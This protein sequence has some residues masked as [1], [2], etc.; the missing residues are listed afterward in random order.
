MRL[1]WNAKGDTVSTVVLW[2]GSLIAALVCVAWLAK[3]LY[4]DHITVQAVD[5]ELTVL[6]HDLNTA[7]RMERFWKNYYPKVKSGTLLIN[8][9]Q[10]CMD[11]SECKVIYYTT[12]GTEPDYE[13]G[14]IMQNNSYPCGNVEHCSALYYSAD[15]DPYQGS[16]YIFVS[17]GTSCKSKRQPIVRCRLLTCDLNYSFSI[18]LENVTGVNMTRDENGTFTAKGY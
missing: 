6:Q 18:F 3:N 4:P 11:S 2:V 13:D 17:N 1:R 8:R 10:V 14:N 12:N 15:T 16:D 9:M 7:C 5:N